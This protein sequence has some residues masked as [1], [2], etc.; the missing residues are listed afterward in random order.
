[1]GGLGLIFYKHWMGDYQRD[2]GDLSLVEHGA[3]RLLLDHYYATEKPLPPELARL[4][5]IAKAVTP[6]EQD[7]LRPMKNE[8]VVRKVLVGWDLTDA[9]TGEVVPFNAEELDALLVISPTP[10]ATALAFWESVNG[11]RAKN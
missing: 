10:L 8:D 4:N 6:E 11:A 9:D 1:M 2:T 5:R 7:E 3:F